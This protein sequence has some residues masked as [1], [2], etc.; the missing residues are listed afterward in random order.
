MPLS[1][2]IRFYVPIVFVLAVAGIA[3]VFSY[4]RAG[5]SMRQVIEF[6]SIVLGGIVGIYGL[7]LNVQSARN[8]S[9]RKFIERWTDPQFGPY[10]KVLSQMVHGKDPTLHSLDRQAIVAI[11]N[12][13]EELAIAV[14]RGEA[15]ESILRDFFYTPALV[16]FRASE[17]WIGETR[18]QLNQPTAYTSFEKLYRRWEPT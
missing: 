15:D 3:A 12:F 14:L 18:K 11:L 6:G 1:I 13:W 4:A 16:C 5:A 10:R 9:A 7:L 17:N 8:A 2:K